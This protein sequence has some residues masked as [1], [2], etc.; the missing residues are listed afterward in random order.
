MNQQLYVLYVLIWEGSVVNF[1]LIHKDFLQCL[2]LQCSGV[3]AAGLFLG[4]LLW[5]MKQLGS[6]KSVP[7]IGSHP[8]EEAVPR[9]V[10]LSHWV[11]LP[12]PLTSRN[13][14][15]HCVVLAAGAD[16]HDI[17]ILLQMPLAFASWLHVASV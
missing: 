8:E 2:G 15:K 11:V 5:Q 13:I 17:L 1:L 7:K 12:I 4:F 16:K 6:V 14:T 10:W 9:T 3:G